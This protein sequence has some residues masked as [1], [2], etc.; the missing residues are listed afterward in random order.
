M[1][2]TFL[3]AALWLACGSALALEF[4][5][6]QERALPDPESEPEAVA[7]GDVSGDG[8]NDIVMTSMEPG[9]SFSVWIFVQ[10]PDG[11]FPDTPERMTLPTAPTTA[12]RAGLALADLDGDGIQDIL[13]GTS[14]GLAFAKGGLPFVLQEKESLVCGFWV[15]AAD[16]N[17]DGAMD[18]VGHCDFGFAVIYY[19]DGQGGFLGVDYAYT[20][21]SGPSDLEIADF[22]NDGYPD[23]AV[24]GEAGAGRLNIVYNNPPYAFTTLPVQLYPRYLPS[25][26]AVGDFNNDGRIDAVTAQHANRGASEFSSAISVYL[27]QAN[28]RFTVPLPRMASWDLPG[29]MLGTD[30]D[31]DG[32][33]DLVVA[34]DGGFGVGYYLQGD[35]GLTSE[36]LLPMPWGNSYHKNGLAVGDINGDGLKDFALAHDAPGPNRIALVTILGRAATQAAAQS[37]PTRVIKKRRRVRAL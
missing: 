36:V 24:T 30:L 25:G 12:Y 37:Q 29:P 1:I 3:A 14:R 22:N 19:G 15:A 16:I 21:A 18:V 17:R 11:H 10:Q 2:R 32:R 8:R 6:Y 31:G 7:I 34:H 27:Q 13:V 5:P 33:D 26:V 20:H 23:L 4:A 28:G 9:K 35:A